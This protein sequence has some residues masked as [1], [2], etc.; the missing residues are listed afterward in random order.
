MRLLPTQHRPHDRPIARFEEV[1][2][3]KNLNDVLLPADPKFTVQR[4]QSGPLAGASVI[5]AKA[6]R[7]NPGDWRGKLYRRQASRHM[8]CR[9][10]AIP[11]F[12]WANRAPGEMLVWIKQ[13]DQD[14]TNVLGEPVPP[15]ND[16]ERNQKGAEDHSGWVPARA[17][18]SLIFA[19]IGASASS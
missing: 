18:N 6:W 15:A 12:M 2:N 1:D 13:A 9:I 19:R 5:H 11:Y 17:S 8:P 16:D 3:G 4:I 7:R 10:T 14:Q